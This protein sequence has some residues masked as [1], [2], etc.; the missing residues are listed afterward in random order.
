MEAANKF[1]IEFT[2]QVEE[3]E[4]EEKEGEQSTAQKKPAAADRSTDVSTRD[5]L[6]KK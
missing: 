6:P 4:D 2:S 1:P 3:D 5:T